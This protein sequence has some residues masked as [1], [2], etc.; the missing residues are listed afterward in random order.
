MG[1]GALTRFRGQVRREDEGQVIVVVA[2]CMAGC[3]ERVWLRERG[4]GSASVP[5]DTDFYESF[6]TNFGTN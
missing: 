5:F 2:V 4:F 6:G 1:V 3:Q